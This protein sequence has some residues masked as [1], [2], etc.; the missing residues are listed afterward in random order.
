MDP[1]T[2]KIDPL[3]V[4]RLIT[5]KTTGIIGLH[6]WGRACDTEALE[7]IG[8]KHG[9][10]VMYDAAHALG[11]SRRGKIIGGFGGCEVFSFHATQFLNSFE[12]GPSSP[13]MIPWQ[14]RC[15]SCVIL[16]LPATIASSS[17]GINGKMTEVCAAMGLTSL[18]AV[19]DLIDI[20]RQNYESPPDK[21]IVA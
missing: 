14:Q 1:L 7:D 17:R 3:S 10:K 16:D 20:N 11:C 5:P 8:H 21:S 4:E 2:H 15:A 18:E 19:A 12:G 6:V 9:L 13:T